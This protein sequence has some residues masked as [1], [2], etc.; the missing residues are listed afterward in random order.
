MLR[1]QSVPFAL[2][3]T[4]PVLQDLRPYPRIREHFQTR[5]RVVEGSGGYLLVEAD[6]RA[7]GRWALGLPCFR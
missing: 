2:A 3:T 4:D 1:Q 5:Y 7:T 6:R